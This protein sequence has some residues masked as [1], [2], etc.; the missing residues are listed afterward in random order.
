MDRIKKAKD[1]SEKE[2]ILQEMGERLKST[3]KALDEDKK[4]QEANLV[5]LLKQRQ[6][7]NIKQTIK[8]IDDEVL[9]LYNKADALKV[10]VDQQKAF[11]FAS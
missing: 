7:K 8:K 6:K 4:R 5:K 9:E 3:E 1:G 10:K 2:S 11:S